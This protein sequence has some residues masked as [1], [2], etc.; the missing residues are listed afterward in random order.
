MTFHLLV[1]RDFTCT[2]F[3]LRIVTLHVHSWMLASRNKNHL[4][5]REVFVAHCALHFLDLILSIKLRVGFGL[6]SGF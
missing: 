5:Q 1:D 4:G 6:C 2:G 3:T